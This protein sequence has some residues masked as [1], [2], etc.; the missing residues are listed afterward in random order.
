MRSAE[1]SSHDPAERLKVLLVD[2][3]LLLIESI[4]AALVSEYGFHVTAATDVDSALAEV[5]K[6]GHF[7]VILLDYDVPGMDS[8]AGLQRLIDANNGAVALFSG[9]ANWTVVER[10]MDR[11]ASGFVP[12]TLPLRILGHAIRFIADGETYLPGDYMR[13]A[14]TEKG[15]DYGLKPREFKVLALLC[16]GKQNKEIGRELGMDEVIVK[17]DVKS[18]CRKLDARNRTQAVIV[19]RDSGLF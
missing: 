16:E 11:G 2:D 13:R 5:D 15:K 19:A 12:K 9:V 3:H 4:S 17:M 6:A 7:D 14:S 8:L 10:A 1:A 18:I